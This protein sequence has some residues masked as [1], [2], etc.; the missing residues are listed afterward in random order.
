MTRPIKHVEKGLTY[1]AKG[2]F[3]AIKSVNQFKPNPSFIP[4]IKR[5]SKREKKNSL[6][7]RGDTATDGVVPWR[8]HRQQCLLR[9]QTRR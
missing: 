9:R 2:A 6:G 5:R 4:K 1:I 8:R 3:N 7:S